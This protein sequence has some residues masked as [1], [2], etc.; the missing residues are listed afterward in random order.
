MILNKNGQKNATLLSL[1]VEIT[2]QPI[3]AG[4][5]KEV[6]S[7]LGPPERNVAP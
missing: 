3:D 5:S 4:R 2:R 6:D 7:S 1:K